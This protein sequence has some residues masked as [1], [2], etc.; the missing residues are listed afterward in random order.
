[1]IQTIVS[2]ITDGQDSLFYA[3]VGQWCDSLTDEVLAVS[4]DEA[5]RLTASLQGWLH[6][7]LVR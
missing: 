6:N 4:A 2:R 3:S 7:P 5:H 1:M